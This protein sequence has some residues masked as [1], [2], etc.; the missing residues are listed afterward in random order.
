MH[1]PLS[2]PSDYRILFFARD[3]KAFGFLSHF[4]PSPIQ[5]DNKLWPTVE[6]FFQA[7]KSDDP[8]YREAIHAA[9]SPAIAKRLAAHPNAHPLVSNDSWFRKHSVMPR[10][11]WFQVN[12]QVMRRGDLAKFVQHP[13]LRASLLATQ[14]AELIEDSPWDRFWGTGKDA[15][16]LNWAGKILMEIRKSLVPKT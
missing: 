16:G 7:Q 14:E 10:P 5:L 2:I 8:A 1:T 15:K 4:H 12:L 13:D 11:D 3:R 9:P 6:H